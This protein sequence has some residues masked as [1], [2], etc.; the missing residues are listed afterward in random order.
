MKINQL[1]WSTIFLY[2]IIACQNNDSNIK[3]QSS[4]ISTSEVVEM[5][6]ADSFDEIDTEEKNW[7]DK[8]EGVLIYNFYDENSDSKDVV[9]YL[10]ENKNERFVF[11]QD[12][13]FMEFKGEE[14]VL[15]EEYGQKDIFENFGI[16]PHIFELGGPSIFHIFVIEQTD[17]FYKV[18]FGTF[19]AFIE[20][21]DERFKFYSP[22]EYL[23]TISIGTNLAKNPV[24][25]SP[26]KDGEII[27]LDLE[28]LWAFDVLEVKGDW[29]KVQSFNMCDNIEE[30]QFK[31]FT[32]WIKFK[33]KEN[34]LISL[35]LSC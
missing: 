18:D 5:M 7:F 20:K 34:L 23:K 22:S 6:K 4:T 11:N 32:G 28:L 33:N 29:I 12:T 1:I 26:E 17:E 19:D 24:R 35:F 10:D 3:M 30:E 16:Q 27:Q 13:D 15:F 9:I 14:Y 8:V 25:K 31:D 2:L 21:T